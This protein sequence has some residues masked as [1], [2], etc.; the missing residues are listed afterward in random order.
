MLLVQCV[1][2]A[3]A[4]LVC[5]ISIEKKKIPG[6]LLE[7]GIIIAAILAASSWVINS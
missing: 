6:G 3:F 2:V 7:W 5:L 1:I 4:M